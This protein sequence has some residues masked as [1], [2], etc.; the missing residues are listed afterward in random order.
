[1]DVFRPS[2]SACSKKRWQ[3]GT[4]QVDFHRSD[5]LAEAADLGVKLPKNLGDLIYSFRFRRSLPP[6][7]ADTAPAGQEWIIELAGNANYRFSL[8]RIS[9]IRPQAAL[10][11]I[12]IPK[13]TPD[14]PR[15][16]SCCATHRVMNRRCWPSCVTT[17]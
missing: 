13:A 9:R 11:V 2:S 7:I 17:A 4:Q 1:M 15:P 8:A 16:R 10:A 14:T 5:I 3:P 6:A 12:D